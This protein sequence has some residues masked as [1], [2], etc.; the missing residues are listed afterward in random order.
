MARLFNRLT[1]VGHVGSDP[2]SKVRVQAPT[3][4]QLTDQ[5]GDEGCESSLAGQNRP[6]R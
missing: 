4:A 3:M 1:W 6:Q 5:I 2:K